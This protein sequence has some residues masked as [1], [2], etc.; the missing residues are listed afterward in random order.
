MKNEKLS[1]TP[2]GSPEPHET[3]DAG[4]SNP[5]SRQSPPTV[6]SGSAERAERRRAARFL[7]RLRRSVLPIALAF[8][9]VCDARA[10]APLL[11]P[12]FEL[13]ATQA[14]DRSPF[15]LTVLKHSA[16]PF[17][18]APPTTQVPGRSPAQPPA[19]D[20]EDDAVAS[21]PQG[22]GFLRLISPKKEFYVGELVP[23]ELKAYFRAGLELRVD[24]LP[25]LN[26]DAFTMNKLSD[27]PERSQ[28]VIGGVPYTALTLS[29][30]I[31]AVKAGDYAMSVEIPTTVTVRQRAQRPRGSMPNP[32]GN[33]FFDEIFNY[34]FFEN[35]F[36]SAT[37]KET[38]LSSPASAVRILPIPVENRPAGFFGAVGKFE[39][40]AEAV[41]TQTAP[42]DPVTLKI[43]ISGT[44]N[45]DRVTAPV[46]EQS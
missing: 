32:F 33:A 16:D 25:K 41:P 45:F 21:D 34:S 22:F 23:V 17:P 24:G 30:A 3:A 26:S 9:S 7:A 44:G 39:L 4:R 36:G 13:S 14:L 20:V 46:L 2:T 5:K 19:E 11:T 38:A 8:A 10:K 6:S 15:V 31:T 29:P 35:F 43:R 18:A 1:K 28:Q 12:A 37:Q 40:A 42:G 27:Q